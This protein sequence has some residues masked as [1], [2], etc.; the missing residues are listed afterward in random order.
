MSTRLRIWTERLPLRLAAALMLAVSLI[1]AY[2]TVK[3]LLNNTSPRPWVLLYMA[4]PGVLIVLLTL[5]PCRISTRQFLAL[6]FVAAL[7]L[8]GMAAV[9]IPTQPESDFW[10]LYDAARQLAQGQNLLNTETY[11]QRWPYQSGFVAWMA[12]FIR[13]FGAGVP[14]FQ[15]TNALC[16]AAS[17]CLIYAIVRRFSSE[18]GARGAALF[19]LLYPGVYFLLPVL[20]NQHLSELLLLLAL[21]ACTHPAEGLR[22]RCLWGGA[23]GVLL[24]LSNGIRP[25]AAVILLAAA[26]FA[27]MGL[28]GWISRRGETLWATLGPWA[29][30]LLAYFL[31]W[32]LLN[33]VTILSGLNC[34]GLTNQVPEWKWILGL[35][36]TT[37]GGYSPSDAA[38]V[39]QS[40]RPVPQAAGD[41]LRQRLAL[42]PG[43]LL[44]LFRDKI[45]AMWG[46]FEDP[47]WA[48]TGQVWA[49]LARL[50]W[51]EQALSLV[52]KLCRLT[53]GMYVWISLL[54]G[55]GALAQLRRPRPF[56]WTGTLAMLCAL[57]YFAAHLFIEIQ[58]RYR[59][60][61][62]IFLILLGGHGFQLCLSGVERLKR[63]LRRPRTVE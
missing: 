41:L 33:A 46:S 63:R 38:A 14:F 50:G 57:A 35:N 11:F 58:P 45:R 51:G 24:A 27:A 62:T 25:M 60:T 10:K 39:F 21:W 54:A 47:S 43:D 37:H 53:S 16:S 36:P 12:F 59:S 6:L 61:M 7:L 42:S 40:G 20:T 29:C 30:F 4:L 15:L 18:A 13:W 26:A 48:F 8:K 5:L 31:S 22:G 2:A 19:Y 9:L 23:G 32:R 55:A 17:N 28:L 56:P 49:D 3:H 44:E 52:N 34:L 1:I